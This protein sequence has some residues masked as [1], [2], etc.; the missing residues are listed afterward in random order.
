VVEQNPGKVV[1]VADFL[2]D[3]ALGTLPF[4]SLV[5]PESQEGS[6]ENPQDLQ[7]GAFYAAT[8]INAVMASPAWKSTVLVLTFDEH[9]GYYDHVP[10]V[11]AARPDGIV[12]EVGTNTYG[13][14]YSWT[15]FRVPTVVVSPWARANYV[16][17]TVF[18]HTSILRLIETKWNLP[19]LSGRDA[20]AN[21]MLDTLDFRRPAFLKPPAMPAAP[22]PAGAVGCILA[23][24]RAALP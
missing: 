20:N 24:P 2:V 8:V 11:P 19:A 4:F 10:P 17:H 23:D 21:N 1:P 13:D 12:P 5:D 3:C 15:G 7:V 22:L 14:L 18:D 9:G 16:S 6:E